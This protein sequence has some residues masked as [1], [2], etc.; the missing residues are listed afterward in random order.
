MCQTI[1]SCL[2]SKNVFLQIVVL[3]NIPKK[4]RR[5]GVVVHT[6]D[7]SDD[8]EAADPTVSFEFKCSNN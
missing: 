1:F 4:K 5:T 2:V 6:S 8:S 3:E 7:S